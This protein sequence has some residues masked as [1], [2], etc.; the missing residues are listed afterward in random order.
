MIQVSSQSSSGKS[1]EQSPAFLALNTLISPAEPVARQFEVNLGAFL[2]F[3]V[4]VTAQ[5]RSLTE[6]QKMPCK[7]VIGDSLNIHILF[8]E[9]SQSI[10]LMHSN[11]KNIKR[12]WK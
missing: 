1:W 4:R 8:K 6:A 9:L 2:V 7:N 12:P 10:A 3:T 5:R 11:N